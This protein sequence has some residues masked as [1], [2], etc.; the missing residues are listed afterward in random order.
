M[1]RTPMLL[2]AG[3][4]GLALTLPLVASA[5]HRPGHQQ[6]TGNLTIK[7]SANPIL[8][9]RSV[10]FTGRLSGADSTG[11]TIELQHDPFPFGTSYD[12]LTTTTTNTKGEY[13]VTAKPDRNTNFRT[14]ANTD[15]RSLSDNLTVGVRMRIT[16]R[17]S[18]RTP[19]R[20]QIVVF[21]GTV[22][23]AHD[24]RRVRI[25]RRRSTGTWRTV[26][27]PRLG[28]PTPYALGVSVYRRGLR[29]NRDGVFRVSIT[30]HADH[31]GNKTRR[32]RLDV[33]PR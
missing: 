32:I 2:I 23:P 26:A 19:A 10:T 17:V 5:H 24:G 28:P 18:D 11:K 21:R 20:G 30:P 3:T 14:V 4:A 15:P 31:V 13:T 7:A 25:Q 8:F 27:R 22:K 16:R 9:G 33:P 29:I 12:T 6:G 1:K